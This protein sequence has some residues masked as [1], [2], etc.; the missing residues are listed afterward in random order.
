MK[1]LLLPLCVAAVTALPL[2]SQAASYKEVEVTNGGSIT[3]AVKFTGKDQPPKIYSIS[4][5]ND[6]CGNDKREIDYIRVANGH[7]Q[8]AVVYLE[9]VKEGKPFPPEVGDATIDQEGCKFS[10]FLQVMKNQA[11]L[12][13][14]NKDPVL[15]NIHTYE[16]I[17]GD[18]KGPKKTIFNISQPDP[19]TVT[20]QVKMKRGAAMKVEC[21]AHDFM[22]S[23]V[24]VAKNPYY[25]VVKED[26][27]FSLDNVPPGKYT[28]KA[29]HGMLKNQKTKVEV[30]A[31]AA[32]TVDF[33]FK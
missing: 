18:A 20:N 10:P 6:V 17:R 1:K 3:G 26:G 8:D 30:K 12:A 13:A 14:I 21:D 33:T 29:W 28:I 5:D 24:F 31:A 32:T 7:L 27:T 19:N 25:A 15:H 23:F 9:K 4:K 16:L 22:H 11:K 2:A